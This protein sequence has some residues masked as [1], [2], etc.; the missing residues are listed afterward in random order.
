VDR[1]AGGRFAVTGTIADIAS[2]GVSSIAAW[3]AACSIDRRIDGIAGLHNAVA[4][5]ERSGGVTAIGDVELRTVAT[6]DG[7]AALGF[8]KLLSAAGE[9][10][11]RTMAGTARSA[12]APGNPLL[13]PGRG[14]AA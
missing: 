7:V 6:G 3:S 9:M 1:G 13:L 4:V 2:G 5:R 14:L 11:A 10:D 8:G 12:A